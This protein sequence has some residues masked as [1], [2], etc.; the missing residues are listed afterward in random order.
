MVTLDSGLKKNDS[1]FV[2]KVP[3]EQHVLYK[4]RFGIDFR[5]A[6]WLMNLFQGVFLFG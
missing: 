1:K 6:L 5:L 3:Q 4:V 2:Q